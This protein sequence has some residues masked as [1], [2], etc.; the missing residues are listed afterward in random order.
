[1]KL[2][3][4][5]DLEKG[6]VDTKFMGGEAVDGFMAVNTEELKQ[7]AIKW[8]K[9]LREKRKEI[10]ENNRYEVGWNEGRQQFIQEFFDITEE[11]LK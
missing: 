5:K 6:W 2:K 4:L 9:M 1:M 8:I 3:T 11:D 10:D 7:E